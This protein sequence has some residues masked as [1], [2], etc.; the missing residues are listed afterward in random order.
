MQVSLQHKMQFILLI[1]MSLE[2]VIPGISDPSKE[3]FF[4]FSGL[5]LRPDHV[6][7]RLLGAVVVKK[8]KTAEKEK[9]WI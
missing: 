3:S 1:Q 5:L 8:L 9:R 6:Q 2:E 4:L 7:T